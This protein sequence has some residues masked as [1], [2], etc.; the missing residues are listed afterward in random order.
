MI[1]EQTLFRRP[2]SFATVRQLTIRGT[3]FEIGQRLGNLA[4][5]RYG[6]SAADYKANTLF[7]KMRKT[8]FLRNYPIHSERA[9]G[10]AEA[11]GVDTNDD[12]Y[13]FTGLMYNMDVSPQAPGCSVVYYPPSSTANGAGYLSRNYDFPIGSLADMMRAPGPSCLGEQSPPLMSEPYIMAWYP[14]DGGYSSLAIHGFDLL[15]GTL[16][17]MNSAGL[18]VSILAEDDV[19]ASAGPNLERHF[20]AQQA[21]GLHELQVMRFLLDTCATTDEARSAVLMVKQ[22]YSFAPCHYIVADK[23]GDSFVY[24][25]SIGRNKQYLINGDGK[26]QAITNF[27]IYRHGEPKGVGALS[28]ENNAFWRYEKL[29]DLITTHQTPFNADDAKANNACVNI[30]TLLGALRTDP[31]QEGAAAG[32]RSRTLWHSLYDQRARTAEFSFYLGEDAQPN[33]ARIER[34]SDYLKIALDLASTNLG[35]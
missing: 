20:G 10:V 4:I 34:R 14:E 1:N 2:D 15:S 7:A 11:F 21:I 13:D 26:P 18:A 17:G 6:K 29:R 25:N 33:G 30:Q 5:E 12:R 24:E 27:Q 16:D 19:I 3:N 31:T 22:Y 28:V 32:V 9:R 8:Y 23:A 35:R